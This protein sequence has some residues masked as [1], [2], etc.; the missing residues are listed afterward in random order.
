MAARLRLGVAGA[1]GIPFAAAA[2]VGTVVAQFWYVAHRPL[3]S[4][5][6][7][8]PDG[9]FGPGSAPEVRLVLLGDSTVTGPGLERRDDLWS[10][11]VARRLAGDVRVRLSSVAA[12]GSR[13]RDVLSAQLA[14][15]QE[16]RPHVAVVS[17]GANDAMHGTRLRRFESDLDALVDAF[18]EAGSQVVLAGV[19]DLG[20]IPRLVHPLKALASRRSRQFDRAHAR[21]A[22]RH[23][24]VVK[25][26]VA[27]LT[28]EQ[29]RAR[30]VFCPDL[31]HPNG[32]GHTA[33]AEAAYPFVSEA[34]A[35]AR[36]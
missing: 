36:A 30:D 7:L 32:A 3:P 1:A 20:N 18:G 17:V 33:W 25:V 23:D 6:D 2:A 10:R 24:H 12:G 31:F 29:F 34:L 35:Q 9:V 15:A 5:T 16:L 26:P 22:A 28:D 27:E 11:Q 13:V 19:G 21:V 4:F 14:E 8:D